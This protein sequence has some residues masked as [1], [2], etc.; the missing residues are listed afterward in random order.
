MDLYR[1]L[2][3]TL[4]ATPADIERAYLRLA[5]RYHP[6]INPGDRLGA[7]RFRVVQE[8]YEV[9]GDPASRRRYDQGQREQV[10]ASVEATVAFDGFDFSAVAQGADAATF[11]ELFADV[12]QGAA[13][14]AIGQ[15]RGAPLELTMQVTFEEAIL[16]GPVPVSVVRRERC[17]S[18][19][20]AGVVAL[21]PVM[22]SVCDG[23]GAT[24]WVRGHMV[25]TKA[26]EPCGGSGQVTRMACGT[27]ASTGVQMRSE[28][29]TVSLPPGIDTHARLV[30]PGRGHVGERGGAAGDLY[31]TVEVVP[32]RMFRRAGRDLHVTVPVAIHEAV[33]GAR[34]D[35]PALDG[36]VKLRVPAGTVSGTRLRVRGYGVPAGQSHEE[37]GDLIVDVQLVV[38]PVQDERSKAL[39]RE[40]ARLNPSDVRAHLFE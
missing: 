13:R 4:A 9:L 32:H 28:V 27:C 26:C 15:D 8:A 6:G 5:R 20:G 14:R 12:F 19:S 24:R 35:V 18:C 30:V 11:S 31:V 1:A 37:A 22:C 34:I 16:G 36:V 29:V 21:D 25:F 7:E 33:F 23:Q 38:P 39:L 3:L 2:D 10:V 40:F 17:P